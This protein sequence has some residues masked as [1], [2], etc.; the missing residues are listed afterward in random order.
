MTASAI[1]AYKPRDPRFYL[2][3]VSALTA[4]LCPPGNDSANHAQAAEAGRACAAVLDSGTVPEGFTTPEA[5]RL[6]SLV[7]EREVLHAARTGMPVPGGRVAPSMPVGALEREEKRLA[8]AGPIPTRDEV[9]AKSKEA[10][11]RLKNISAPVRMAALTASALRIDA[12]PFVTGAPSVRNDAIGIVVDELTKA[13]ELAKELGVPSTETLSE[14]DA[15]KAGSAVL[16]YPAC[17]TLD[18]LII[19]AA[20]SQ[21]P[22]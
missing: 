3:A 13:I 6:L 15:Q 16:P 1:P 18:M 4:A 19:G 17:L 12:I 2:Q 10:V 5:V 22:A 14:A 9:N 8:A 7:G 20:A 11:E 21:E